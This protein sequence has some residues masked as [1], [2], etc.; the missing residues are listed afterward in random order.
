M[1]KHLVGREAR[2]L[3][4][5]RAAAE[6]LRAGRLLIAAAAGEW[7]RCVCVHRI[8]GFSGGED[9]LDVR[10]DR[11]AGVDHR[12]FFFSEEVGIGAG[13]GHHPGIGSDQPR[14]MAVEPFGTPGARS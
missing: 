8:Q 12:E 1:V 9:L 10:V 2:V 6:D 4:R 5:G 14:D 13:T 3:A 7:S 11:R